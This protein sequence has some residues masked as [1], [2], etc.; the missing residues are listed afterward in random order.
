MELPGH[1]IRSNVFTVGSF[2]HRWPDEGNS[3]NSNLFTSAPTGNFELH[4]RAAAIDAGENIPGITDGTIHGIAPDAGALEYRGEEN[5]YWAAGALIR[6]RDRS[7]LRFSMLVKPTGERFIVMSGLPKGR[8][9]SSECRIQ[10]GSE[11][12]AGHRLTY[13]TRT[14]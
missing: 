9:P 7:D 2:L 5:P 14:H 1:I 6:S 8:V 10:L 12:L 13:S 3:F 11:I 4:S